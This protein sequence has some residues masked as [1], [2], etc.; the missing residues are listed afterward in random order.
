[1]LCRSCTKEQNYSLLVQRTPLSPSCSTFPISQ[2]PNKDTK[3]LFQNHDQLI[4]S[5]EKMVVELPSADLNIK[6]D[7]CPDR[8]SHCVVYWKAYL[9]IVKYFCYCCSWLPF[10]K[11]FAP[12]TTIDLLSQLV[13]FPI[14]SHTRFYG[15]QLI[16]GSSVLPFVILRVVPFV[17]SSL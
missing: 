2:L 14:A 10:V 17:T 6:F 16:L 3:S 7:D 5:F 8:T 1:M 15:K 11:W 9:L 13:L 4:V 12:R